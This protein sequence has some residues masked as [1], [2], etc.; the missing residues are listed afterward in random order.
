MSCPLKNITLDAVTSSETWGGFTFGI[1]SSD[2]TEYAAALSRV[3]MTWKNSSGTVALTLDSN[4]AGQI[5]I[6]TATPYEWNFT[7]EPRVLGLTSGIY[8]WAVETTDADGVID[9]NRLAGTHQID[10]SPHS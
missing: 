1:D 7:T 10:P 2:D 3:R 9:E 8:S 5:T 4:T 6:N